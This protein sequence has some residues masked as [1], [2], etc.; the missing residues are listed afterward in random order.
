MGGFFKKIIELII[1]NSCVKIFNSSDRLRFLHMSPNNMSLHH[2]K[3]TFFV[4]FVAVLPFYLT[5]F[6]SIKLARFDSLVA[7]F[8]QLNYSLLKFFIKKGLLLKPGPGP[9]TLDSNPGPGPWTWTRILNADP[10][11]GPWTLDP[12]P[13][14]SGLSKTWTL[15]NLE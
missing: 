9:W 14:K 2:M 8:T 4:F 10:E 13:E 15:K 6:K 3:K 7:F 1:D 11:P 12:D 5:K